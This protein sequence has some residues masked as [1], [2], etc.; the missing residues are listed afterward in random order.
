MLLVEKNAA[1]AFLHT[2]WVIHHAKSRSGVYCGWLSFSDAKRVRT[3]ELNY[4]VEKCYCGTEFEEDEIKAERS[5]MGFFN[6]PSTAVL[7]TAQDKR[8][9]NEAITNLVLSSL[10][11]YE[12][13]NESFF[14]DL[15]KTTLK[16]GSRHGRFGEV[17]FDVSKKN[18]L[19][20]G[21]GVRKNL[22]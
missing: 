7:L 12:L 8:D 15:L 20:S 22:D 2:G 14:G 1:G 18:K 11:P 6:A 3:S 21:D 4:H 16:V 10:R 9:L 13:V 17:S 5:I 19:I